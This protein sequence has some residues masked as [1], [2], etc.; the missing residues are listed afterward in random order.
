MTVFFCD[1]KPET[2]EHLFWYCNRVFPLWI[3]L[4]NWIGLVTEIE[5]EFSLESVLLCFTNCM[6]CKDAINCILLKPELQISHF[7]HFHWLTGHRLSA[8]IPALPNMVNEHSSKYT[9]LR[10]REKMADKSRFGSELTEAEIN[11]LVD[12]ATPSNNKKVTKFGMK[13]FNCM[14][15]I[16]LMPM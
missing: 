8:H 5:M 4:A 6:P 16:F 10:L 12:N 7:Q 15:L 3:A 14:Y 13:I 9:V 2:L 1:S 11:A